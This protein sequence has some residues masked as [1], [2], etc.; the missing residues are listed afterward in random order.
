[1]AIKVHPQGLCE[2]DQVGD[3]TRVWAFAHVLPGAVVGRDCNICD[4]AFIE[5][6]AVLGDRVTVKNATLVWRGV[7]CEDDVFL[8]PN[9]L[10]TNDLR[11]R[12]GTP[13]GPED[14]VPTYVR[15]GASLGA[16][17]VVVCGTEIGE[18]AFAAAGSVITRDVLPHSFV[19]GNPAVHKGWVGRCGARLTQDESDDSSIWR[20]TGCD[21]AYVVD[22]TT[23]RL[24]PHSP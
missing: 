14:V 3:G 20:C 10:F 18:Y 21:E 12:S 7:T 9:V 2:S 23:G 1:M 5:D 8:G 6:G 4:C 24:R 15:R 22:D 11:P 19:A 13:F 16:G 17:T